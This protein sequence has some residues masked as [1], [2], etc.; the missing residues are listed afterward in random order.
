M[1]KEFPFVIIDGS[2]Y[3]YRAFH[4]LPPLTNS[5]GQPTGAIYGVINMIRKLLNDFTPKYIAV[6]FDSRVPSFRK[7]MYPEY[8]AHRPPMPTE[9]QSQIS[10]L[11]ELIED[12]GIP[13]IVIDGVE[14]DD[15]IATLAVQAAEQH[16]N[17]LISSGDKDLAQ[18][19]NDKINIIDTMSNKFFDVNGVKEKFGVGPSQILDYLT[20]L[21]DASDNIPGVP[22]VGPKTAVKLLEEY[23]TV[24]NILA[25]VQEISGNLGKNLQASIAQLPMAKELLTLKYDVELG[26]APSDLTRKPENH[27]RLVSLLQELEFKKWLAEALENQPKNIH[28]IKQDGDYKT[29]FTTDEF[30]HLLHELDLASL[31]VIDTETNS[32]D[33][34]SAELVGLSVAIKPKQGI[35]IPLAH[36]YEG[37]PIQLNRSLVLEK[38]KVLLE[39]PDKIKVGHNLKFD[40]EMLANYGIDTQGCLFDTML[41]SYVLNS[42]NPRHDMDSLALQHLKIKT[43]TFEE[44]AGTGKKQ[45]TFNKVHLDKAAPYAAEDA[46]ITLQLHQKLWPEIEAD[47][48]LKHIFTA[49]EMPL[50]SVLAKMERNGVC[51]D[52]DLLNKQSLELGKRIAEIE[53]IIYKESGAVFNIS[54]P[55]QLQ[56]ILYG[57]L[58]LPVLK[59]TP[60]G[61]PSTAEEVLQELAEEY[62][63][64]KL[65]LEYR[66]LSKLKST[67]TDALPLQV[68]PRTH[69]IHTSYNQA[70]TSTGRLSSSNPNLQ[71]IPIKTAEGKKIRQAFIATPQ[72]KIISADYSQIELRIMAHLSQD[73]GLL[74]AFNENLD[75]H[76]ATAAEVF[77]MALDQVSGEQRRRAKAI[78]F[79]LIYGMS[80]FGL[81]KQLGIGREEAQTYMNVYFAR[82]PKIQEYMQ[83]ARIKAKQEGFVE[84][85]FGRK[86]YIPDINSSNIHRRNAAE[87]AAINGPMQGTAADI[88]KIAMI[89]IDKW[90]SE[91]K[92]DCKM[93]MQVHDEL[94][95]EVAEKDVEVALQNVE[96][97]MS[98]A[99][100]LSVPLIVDVT[101][102]ENWN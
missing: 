48:G 41:E 40:I 27:P 52:V 20:L 76:S 56:E 65:I 44:V 102:G 8:K 1:N 78:N 85:I 43:T 69:R 6:V 100:Q 5:K 59:K 37:A 15:V 51:I 2:S 63:L 49:I 39:N 23:Q 74:K 14:A 36:D 21:G 33:P 42:T 29:I 12:M 4:A 35:Y 82:Y 17:T 61:Q 57:K 96:N 70:V 50:V 7:V 58:L 34:I 13:L 54:S 22:G 53:A 62:E 86:L 89:N 79:G 18:L 16:I 25:H 67:Y 93:I 91:S 92:L 55:K 64:P 77:S 99:A 88:I 83:I 10:L 84:T 28:T 46:D 101:V 68:N 38:L 73:L 19:V 32:L 75:I 95:F 81:A 30:A 45:V 31:F 72:H 98:N 97:L 11:H 47:K 3:L 71:N 9:L 66:S 87:R 26:F 94:V 24:E 80:A 60:G 90:I